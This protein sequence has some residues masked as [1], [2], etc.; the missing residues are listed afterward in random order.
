MASERREP[1]VRVHHHALHDIIYLIE[2]D[3][4]L[5][6]RILKHPRTGA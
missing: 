4:I 2:D 6:V 5:I 3:H 1:P